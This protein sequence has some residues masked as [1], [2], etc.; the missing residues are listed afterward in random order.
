MRLRHGSRAPEQTRR[1]H[2]QSLVEFAIVLPVLG[3]FLLGMLEM[4]LAF[5]HHLTI[6]YA[7]R[8]GSR[9]GSGLST[10][11]STNCVGGVD[12][13]NIDQQII[14]AV[15]RILKSPGSPISMA[16][17]TEIRL[18]RADANGNQM[19]TQANVW[20]PT[21]GAGPDIDPGVGVDRLDFTQQSSG[22]HVCARRNAS[23]NPDSIGVRIRYGYVWQTPL[24]AISDLFSGSLQT[25]LT[26]DDR[27]VMSL[28]PTA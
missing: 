6:E 22:W 17:V 4:G 28:N 18:Y 13:A 25:L 9:T 7:T 8:E 10:G 21:P 14:A 1:G 27:T 19:G 26:I 3:L 24:G 12:A 5:S 11:G 2:G 20:G 16:A 15:Q 23:P